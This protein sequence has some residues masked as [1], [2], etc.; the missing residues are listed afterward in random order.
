MQG[1]AIAPLLILPVIWGGYYVALNASVAHMS[2]FSVGIVIRFVTMIFLTIIILAKKQFGTLKDI[3]YVWPRLLL[4]GTLGFLLDATA[5]LGLTLCPAGIGTVLL[6]S[7]ILFVNLISVVVYKYHFSKKDWLYTLVMLAGVVLVLGIDFGNMKLGGAGNLFFLLSALFVSINAFVIKS[8]QHDKR[9]PVSDNV[10]AYYNNFI[11]MIYFTIFAS[12]TGQIGQLQK[13]GENHYVTVALLLG[14]V[15][16]TLVYIVYYNNLR[17]YEVW[18]VKVFLLLMPIV[19]TFLSYFLF[20]ETMK[21]S[22]LVG[23]VVV[24]GGAAG[25]IVE[26]GKAK[27]KPAKAKVE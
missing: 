26:Q 13:L 5:F 25:I 6:K 10:V 17:K 1:K 20:G 3:R 18:L 19:V 2:L 24:L 12:F 22:Q 15:G 11:T 23:M 4:I 8:V 9:N 14:S 21:L 16:Q 27:V 7:D